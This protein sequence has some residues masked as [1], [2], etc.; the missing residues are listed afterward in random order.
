MTAR[1][2]WT[3]VAVVLDGRQGILYTNGQVAAVNNSINLLPSDVA[4]TNNFFGRSKFSADAYFNGQ[5][6]SVKLNSR[7]IFFVSSRISLGVVASIG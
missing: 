4:G 3:H 7:T 5:L 1:S 6:D 2:V